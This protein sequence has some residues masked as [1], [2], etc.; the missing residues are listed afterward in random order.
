MSADKKEDRRMVQSIE[1][2]HST[3][4][5]SYPNNPRVAAFGSSVS[6]MLMSII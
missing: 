1:T 2:P 4:A 6:T 5:S 3:Q